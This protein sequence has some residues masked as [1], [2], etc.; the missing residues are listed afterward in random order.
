MR[1]LTHDRF[2][3]LQTVLIFL[4]ALTVLNSEVLWLLDHD[5]T[6]DASMN[7]WSKVLGVMSEENFKL[8]YLGMLYPHIPTYVL[9][10]FYFLPE[11]I[12]SAAP[13]FVSCLFGAGLLAFWNFHLQKKRYDLGDRL[14]LVLLVMA[15]PFFLWSVT[16]GKTSGMSLVMFYL[17]YLASVRLIKEADIRS[18]IMLGAVLGAYFFIDEKTFF[19]YIAFLPL[20]PLIAP[21]N[22][23]DQSPASVYLVITMPLIISVVAWLYLNWVFEG[24]SLSFLTSPYAS[25]RGAWQNVPDIEWLRDY[26]G[27]FLI[28]MLICFVVLVFAYPIVVWLIWRSR[29]HQKLLRGTEV[30]FIHLGLAAGLS[31]TAFFLVH[32]A[33]MLFLVSAGVMA[34]IVLLPHESHKMKRGLYAMMAFSA[35]TGWVALSWKP[36]TEMQAWLDAMT[37]KPVLVQHEGDVRLGQWLRG[38]RLRTLM[39]DHAGYRAIVARGDGE[40]MIVSY[41]LEFQQAL[42][43]DHL[44]VDQVAVM[45]PLYSGRS[46]DMHG[47][48]ML[49]DRMPDMITQ[50]YPDLYQHGMEGYRLVYDSDHWRVYRRLDKKVMVGM[51]Q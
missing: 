17:L 29:R 33:D 26:G 31:T 34:G 8:G 10:P 37:G 24:G 42:R 18:I 30:M 47:S 21:R 28:P 7:R 13:Y 38:N 35:F 2:F 32:P 20:L 9:T 46:Q 16:S 22:M 40:G 14:F 1:K 50:R 25:F 11:Y 15:H 36:T 4:L 39:D 3:T 44:Y 43:S 49:A 5:F 6:S 23:L 41:T 27:E 51:S 19:I 48:D 45:D 12:R